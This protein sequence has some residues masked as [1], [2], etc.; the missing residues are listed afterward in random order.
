MT[1]RQMLRDA[2]E[3]IGDFFKWLRD[4][5]W[6]KKNSSSPGYSHSTYDWAGTMQVLAVLLLGFVAAVISIWIFR[7]VKARRSRVEDAVAASPVLIPDVSREDV[8]ADQLPED[9]WIALA[10]ELMEKGELRLAMRALYLACL[11]ALAQRGSLSI[12][13]FKSNL[14]Y[15]REVRRRSHARPELV[16]AFC[17]NVSLFDRSWYGIHEVTPEILE[18]FTANLQKLQ[19]G[20]ENA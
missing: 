1:F 3:A 16:A 4:K 15:E 19:S 7:T 5:L 12:A 14:D 9:G 17:Q 20:G 2:L 13:W 11:A 6:W 18:M 8:T 10:R